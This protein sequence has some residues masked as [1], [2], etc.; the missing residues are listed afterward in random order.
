MKLTAIRFWKENGLI[1]R[2]NFDSGCKKK[3]NFSNGRKIFANMIIEKKNR[4]RK[5]EKIQFY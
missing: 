1:S 5:K 4:E 2:L 3:D